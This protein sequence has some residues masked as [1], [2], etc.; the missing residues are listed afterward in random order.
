MSACKTT[1]QATRTKSFSG[2]DVTHFAHISRLIAQVLFNVMYKFTL[3]ERANWC[4]CSA[5]VKGFTQIIVTY[6]SERCSA[7]LQYTFKKLCIDKNIIFCPD[8]T[9]FCPFLERFDSFIW[10]PSVSFC[11][12][13]EP[14]S[15]GPVSSVEATAGASSFRFFRAGSMV[16]RNL[17][18]TK[19]IYIVTAVMVINESQWLGTY[20]GF[21]AHTPSILIEDSVKEGSQKIVKWKHTMR[22]I[23]PTNQHDQHVHSNE[24]SM[25][26]SIGLCNR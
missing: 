8:F 9:L 17:W 18:K 5:V 2:I 3:L 15:T 19:K 24:L 16:I 26:K 6:R 20:S 1:G 11:S 10:F 22:K 4:R 12:I 25:S 7:G 23:N 13:M 14:A 21:M